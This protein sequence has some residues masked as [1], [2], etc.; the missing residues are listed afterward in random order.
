M[1]RK[2]NSDLYGSAPDESPVALLIIDC[3]N[4]LEFDDGEALLQVALPMAERIADLKRRARAKNVPV[5]YV[6]D[7]FGHWRSNFAAQVEHCLNDGVRGEPL[8]E[9]LA[10]DEEDYFVLKPKHSGFYSTT[11]EVLLEHLGV[12]TVILTGLSAD[13]CVLFTANDAYMRDLELIVPSDC[14]AANTPEICRAA[15]EQMQRVLKAIVKP[16]SEIDLDAL[17]AEN[18]ARQ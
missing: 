9:R 3:I 13:I 8:V 18:D 12:R 17:V 5:V 7:N 10:P 4:D 15:L 16:S 11:L 14:V 1:V 2:R 6:N